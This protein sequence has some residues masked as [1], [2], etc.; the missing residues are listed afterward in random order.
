MK[1]KPW[2]IWLRG[3][4]SGMEHEVTFLRC[5]TERTARIWTA[6]L[7]DARPTN[8]VIEWEARHR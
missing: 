8:D 4:E 1:W 6:R 2:G 7:N 3:L 5:W